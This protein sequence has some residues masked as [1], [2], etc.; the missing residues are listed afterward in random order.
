MLSMTQKELNAREKMMEKA[1]E[2]TRREAEKDKRP[3]SLI[4][5]EGIHTCPNGVKVEFTNTGRI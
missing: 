3:T 2:R 1:R 4:A 5:Y